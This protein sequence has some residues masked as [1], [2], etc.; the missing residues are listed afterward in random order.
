MARCSTCGNEFHTT[1]AITYHGQTYIFDSFECAIQKLAPSCE[2][3]G[4]RIIGHGVEAA[5]KWFCCEHC[6]REV[7]AAAPKMAHARD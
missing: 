1:M 6:A 7:G 3:C 5:G 4:C 2:H